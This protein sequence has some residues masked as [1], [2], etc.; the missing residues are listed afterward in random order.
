MLTVLTVGVQG[1]LYQDSS[2][3]MWQCWQW[4]CKDRCIKTVQIKCDRDDSGCAR[5]ALSRQFK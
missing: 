4:M 3:K 5:T 1:P 2:N